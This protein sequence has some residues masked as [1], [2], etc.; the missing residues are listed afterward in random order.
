M[1][2]I[3]SWQQLWLA[4]RAR[5]VVGQLAGQLPDLLRV[6]GPAGEIGRLPRIVLQA[7][8]ATT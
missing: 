3:C 6:L 2:I 4:G 8:S 5:Q 7:A 1:H